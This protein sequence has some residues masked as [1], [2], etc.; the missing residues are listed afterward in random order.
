LDTTRGL[1]GH[2][3]NVHHVNDSGKVMAF[4]RWD[5]G[6]PRD[7]V[8][9]VANFANGAYDSYRI[10][11]PRGGIWRVRFNGDWRGYSPAFT[12]HAS[13]DLST[14]SGGNSDNMPFGGD[15]SIGPYTVLILSQDD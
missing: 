10:G 13:Y 15:V 9:V 2:E 12:D 3:I 7:D 4:H 5:R 8:I 11:L 1:N 6:G 14:V